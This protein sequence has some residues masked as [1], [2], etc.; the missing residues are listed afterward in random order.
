MFVNKLYI[1]ID[2]VTPFFNPSSVGMELL[3]FFLKIMV[4]FEMFK[5]LTSVI[6]SYLNF[7]KHRIVLSIQFQDSNQS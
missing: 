4:A 5:L 2:S 7:H 6:N 1:D 3:S